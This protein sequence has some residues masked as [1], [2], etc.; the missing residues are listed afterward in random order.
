MQAAGRMRQLGSNQTLVCVAPFDVHNAIFPVPSKPGQ[1]MIHLL[2]W[3]ISITVH[4]AIA[5]IYEWSEHGQHFAEIL[6]DPSKGLV[7]ENTEL[8]NLYGNALSETNLHEIISKTISSK[9]NTCWRNNSPKT[10]CDIID[11]IDQHAKMYGYDRIVD[12]STID[13]ECEREQEKEQEI[14]QKIEQEVEAEVP[15]PEIEWDYS[16]T[17]SQPNFDCKTKILAASNAITLPIAIAG[18]LFPSKKIMKI[19]WNDLISP[20][21]YVTQNFLHSIANLSIPLPSKSSSLENINEYLRLV[22]SVLVFRDGTMLLLSDGEANGIVEEMWN[23]SYH[24]H[25]H[26]ISSDAPMLMHLY[27]MREH[28]LN[29]AGGPISPTITTSA[30]NDNSAAAIVER[31]VLTLPYCPATIS[32]RINPNSMVR[33]MLFNGETMFKDLTPTLAKFLP[34]KA[35]RDSLL[36]FANARGNMYDVDDDCD[37]QKAHLAS[38]LEIKAK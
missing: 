8:A 3:I 28:I 14:E 32:H 11:H 31:L 33:I 17:V 1:E 35:A 12:V 30:D 25:H 29:S 36:F 9:F 20:A 6:I 13:E 15:S 2:R 38:S 18:S 23:Y 34:N 37:L 19:V 4:M 7:P 26:D 5:G 10:M 22:D 21:I 24:H 16:I 27:A